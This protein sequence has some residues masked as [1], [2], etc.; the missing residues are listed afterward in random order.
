[1]YSL[2]ESCIDT[3]RYRYVGDYD[4]ATESL[5]LEGTIVRINNKQYLVKPALKQDDDDP[6]I[7]DLGEGA[8]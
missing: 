6:G 2:G 8:A 4:T 5:S 7:C 1:M 3:L